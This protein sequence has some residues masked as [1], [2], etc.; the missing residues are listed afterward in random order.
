MR[1]DDGMKP[2]RRVGRFGP[3]PGGT[4]ARHG[5]EVSPQHGGHEVELRHLRHGTDPDGG[6]V[7]HDRDAVADREEFVELVT[8][9]D[10]RNA[11]ALQAPDHGEQAL[12]L[13]VVE[14]RGRLVHDDELGLE[15][16]RASDGDHLL[17]GDGIGIEGT[18]DVDVEIEASEQ[19]A[20][21]GLHAAA[22]EQARSG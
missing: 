2:G 18:P 9:E 12:D 15:A 22:V 4:P 10:R 21:L 5:G 17:G 13:A 11:V 8:D 1:F 19:R 20:G 16:D 6:A 7:A 14:R 3:E